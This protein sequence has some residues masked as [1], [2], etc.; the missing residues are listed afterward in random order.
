MEVRG[1]LP[2]PL[3]TGVDPGDADAD[4]TEH[5]GPQSGHAAYHRPLLRRL[6]QGRTPPPMQPGVYTAHPQPNLE[7]ISNHCGRNTEGK[8]QKKIVSDQI[9]QQDLEDVIREPER[10]VSPPLKAHKKTSI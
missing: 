3:R 2:V 9:R 10:T 6:P 5:A 7:D 1:V 4:Y 8:Q